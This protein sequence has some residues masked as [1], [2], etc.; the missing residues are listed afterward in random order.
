[1]SE[2]SGAAALDRDQIDVIARG[3]Y[4]LANVD[5]IDDSERQVIRQFV[6]EA[7]HPDLLDTLSERP[8]DLNEA[9]DVLETRFLRRLFL[10]AAIVLVRADGKFTEEEQVAFTGV[11]YAFGEQEALSD[12]KAAVANISSFE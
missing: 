6:T 7:G 3:L 10:K 8:F 11:A 5:G 2:G 1:M 9:Y 4:H 12:L